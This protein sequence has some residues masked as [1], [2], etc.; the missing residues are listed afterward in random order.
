[1]S[2]IPVPSNNDFV[3]GVIERHL[4]EMIEHEMQTQ[5]KDVAAWIE[6]RKGEMVAGV[7]V[8]LMKQVEFETLKDRVIITIRKP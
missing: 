3:K 7:M 6:K 2:N 8:D 4:K 1:M 5:L